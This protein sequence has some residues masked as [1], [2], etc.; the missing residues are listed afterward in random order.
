MQFTKMYLVSRLHR[1]HML[2]VITYW[3]IC[4]LSLK[5]EPLMGERQQNM[6]EYYAEYVGSLGLEISQAASLKDA[7]KVSS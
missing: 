1:H 3:Q 2:L 5:D 4:L 7:D 6:N